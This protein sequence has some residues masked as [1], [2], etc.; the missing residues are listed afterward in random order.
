MIAG[1]AGAVV[2][3][4]LACDTR[5]LHRAEGVTITPS[6]WSPEDSAA[7]EAWG[8]AT[9][10]AC[11]SSNALEPVS[12]HDVLA[13]SFCVRVSPEPPVDDGS[14]FD[15]GFEEPDGGQAE[16]LDGVEG[17]GFTN[18]VGALGVG[19]SPSE[20]A[21]LYCDTDD[22][23]GVRLTRVD[24]ASGLVQSSLLA[25]EVCWSDPETGALTETDEG[26][27]VAWIDLLE[28][29][30]LLTA[31]VGGDGAWLQ[32]PV[33]AE[34]PGGAW[35]V[36]LAGD[37]PIVADQDGTLHELT[38][39]GATELLEQAS[40]FDVVPSAVA[41]CSPDTSPRLVELATRA[42]VTL[43][44]T[45][46][47]THPSLAVSGDTYA[48]A[49]EDAAGGVLSLYA[50]S[51]ETTLTL[52]AD[53]THP[54]VAALPGELGFLLVD[55]SGRM[56]HLDVS[57]GQLDSWLHPDLV[58]REG[59]LLGLRLLVDEEAWGV[60]LL[61]RDSYETDGGHVYTFAYVELSAVPSPLD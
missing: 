60:V 50:P 19:G 2:L 43:R 30:G 32:E 38:E 59:D 44:G 3:L 4:L 46:A 57:G 14:V 12:G 8:A 11:G 40:A 41:G 1:Y 29:P 17:C 33:K 56:R 36:R 10:A 26:Y 55:G 47:E 45:C 61:G 24:G 6:R 39:L 28:G 9:G 16:P 53:A 51:G 49:W 21:V 15:T 42:Q 5:D 18:L 52:G 48:L 22:S 58:D 34:L 20:P 37:V 25:P 27:R 13:P 54:R 35:R 31:D 23:G 7:P